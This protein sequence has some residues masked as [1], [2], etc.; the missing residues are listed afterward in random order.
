MRLNRIAIASFFSVY[1]IW[2]STYLAIRYAIETIPPW[3]LSSFRFFIAAGLMF[4]ISRFRHETPLT[5]SEFKIA[6]VSGACL[7]IANG[8]VCLTEAWIP[9]GV[10]AVVI[11][12]MPIWILLVGWLFFK[13]GRPAPLKFL[14]ALIG[15]CGIA[16]IAGLDHTSDFQ[17][18]HPGPG[19]I[20]G[21]FLLWGSGILWASGT[22]LQRRTKMLVSIFRFSSTQ[23]ISG[24]I[25]TGILSLIFEKPWG[26]HWTGITMISWLSL[27]Y[28]I[29]FGSLVSFSAYL[30]ISRN[31]DPAIVSTYALV[32]PLIAVGL[33]WLFLSEPVD[34]KFALATGLVM[35]GLTLLLYRRRSTAR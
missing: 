21:I 9:S 19:M 27:A 10:V 26:L 34:L 6:A 18:L 1:F 5:Q 33:G 16:L 2:G 22:L 28:L 24:A 23:M 11:G 8:L 20:V 13:E 32:N 12:A 31:F 7:V 4:L 15:V 3:T 30:Y 17:P 29:V 35:I 14:G 25:A